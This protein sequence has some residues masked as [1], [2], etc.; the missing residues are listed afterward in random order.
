[1]SHY[2]FVY[3]TLMRGFRSP[4]N[5]QFDACTRFV[6][7][8]VVKGYLYEIDRYP[9][10]IID[11]SA[12][13]GVYGEVYEI[14]D[15]SLLDVL[16]K[17]ENCSEAFEKPWEYERVLEAIQCGDKSYQAWVYVYRWP[18]DSSNLISSGDYK[19]W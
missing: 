9:G 3:G 18:I 8:G 2:V 14:L 5:E 6:S 1:M 15:Q 7:E 11:H 17:Y 13:Q 4:V 16:D 19:N 12:P 10:L